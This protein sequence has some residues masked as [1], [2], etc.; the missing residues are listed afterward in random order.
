MNKIIV[1]RISLD[2]VLAICVIFGW[3]YAAILIFVV[4]AW[5]FPYFIEAVLAGF[6]YDLLFGAVPGTGVK[7][8]SAM[9]LSVAILAIVC[10]GRKYLRKGN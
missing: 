3:I 10:G 7:A 5:F 4:G 8:Y 6:L 2:I 1:F 9:I